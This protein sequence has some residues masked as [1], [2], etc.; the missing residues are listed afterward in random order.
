M[1]RSIA[2][3]HW[4][5]LRCDFAVYDWGMEGQ[6][7]M[8]REL[9]ITLLSAMSAAFAPLV[10]MSIFVIRKVTPKIHFRYHHWNKRLKREIAR[11][12]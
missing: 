4:A 9:R 7:R 1:A 6:G 10:L 8:S 12:S 11:W 2:K 5:L 3:G